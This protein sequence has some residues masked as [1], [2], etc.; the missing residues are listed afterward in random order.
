MS[1]HLVVATIAAFALGTALFAESPQPQTA[2]S[3]LDSY[4]AQAAPSVPLYRTDLQ[5]GGDPKQVPPGRFFAVGPMIG[6]FTYRAKHYEELTKDERGAVM[7]EPRFRAFLIAT[8]TQED[9]SGLRES[10]RRAIRLGPER[11]SISPE[12]MLR[13][14]PVLVVIGRP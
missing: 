4:L 9:R 6:P 3:L 14:R 10:Q 2:L 5:P 11:F 1:R 12:E 8:R 7:R 13:D